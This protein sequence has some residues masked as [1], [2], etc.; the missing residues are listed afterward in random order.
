VQEWVEM[1][2]NHQKLYEGRL[3]AFWASVFHNLRSNVMLTV[4]FVNR[5]SDIN[6]PVKHISCAP[7]MFPSTSV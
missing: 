4:D 2:M 6:V 5:L 1:G 3:L 7:L